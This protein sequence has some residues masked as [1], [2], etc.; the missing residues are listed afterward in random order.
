MKDSI[1]DVAI[2]VKAPGT[3][4]YVTSGQTK[5]VVRKVNRVEWKIG[6]AAPTYYYLWQSARPDGGDTEEDDTIY[7]VFADAKQALV[8][9]ENERHEEIME[10]ISK[11]R[12]DEAVQ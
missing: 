11:L 4:Y 3:T 1:I 10:S 5:V 7:W 12:V 2:D 9:R 8:D 6:A